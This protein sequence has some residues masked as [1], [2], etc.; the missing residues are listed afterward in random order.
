M[1]TAREREGPAGAILEGGRDTIHGSLARQP[2]SHRGTPLFPSTIHHPTLFLCC[3]PTRFSSTTRWPTFPLSPAFTHTSDVE[4]GLC[5]CVKLHQSAPTCLY[6]CLFRW[7][8]R[9]KGASVGKGEGGTENKNEEGRRGGQQR[10][11]QARGRT[12]SQSQ[13]QYAVASLENFLSI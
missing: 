7:E 4:K 2:A 10:L 9:W 1:S 6:V 8:T 3:S 13:S 5:V 11:S 12:R